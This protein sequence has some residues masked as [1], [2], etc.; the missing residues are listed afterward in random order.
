MNFAHQAFLSVLTATALVAVAAPAPAA[1]ILEP[2]SATT[3]MGEAF[4]L[5]HA[6]D[7]SG[8]SRGYTTGVTRF[9]TY[10]PTATHVSQPGTDWVSN[11]QTGSATFDL[12][13]VFV[14]DRAAV[15]NF[16][17]FIGNPTFA[18]RDIDLLGSSD[19]ILF[20][21]LGSYTLT[22]P[23]GAPSTLA[24]ILPFAPVSAEFIRMEVKSTYG[25]NA[26]LGEIALAQAQV[27]EPASVVLLGIALLAL[28]LARRLTR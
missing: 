18:I 21:L 16:G 22:N 11:S 24:Q 20:T 15:W 13:A 5:V 25:S 26:A 6:I 19:G 10:V 7:Q 12:G 23:N 9:D 3:N 1:V 27:P 2:V 14:V 4:P 17:S 28:G 8:L